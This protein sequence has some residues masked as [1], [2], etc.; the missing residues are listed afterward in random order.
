MLGRRG[1][2]RGCGWHVIVIVIV[3]VIVVRF[4][5][6]PIEQLV[7]LIIGGAGRRRW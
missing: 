3:I 5:G 6:H 4:V 2:R 1:G 7:E